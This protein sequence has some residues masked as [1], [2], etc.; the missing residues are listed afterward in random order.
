MYSFKVEARNAVGY[1]EPSE[2]FTILAAIKPDAP[3]SVQSTN[4]G[5]KVLL[6][7]QAPSED[8]VR[9]YGDS[10]KSYKVYIAHSDM[11]TYSF[12]LVHCDGENDHYVIEA[13]QCE[14]PMLTLQQQPFALA[15]GQPV[16]LKVVTVNSVGDSQESL[17]GAGAVSAQEPDAPVNLARDALQT[18]TT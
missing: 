5:S 1:S 14:I 6:S 4:S 13:A 12:D 2:V 8:P 18:T 10:I 16:M 11:T 7:W 9:D 15:I 17:T 3:T